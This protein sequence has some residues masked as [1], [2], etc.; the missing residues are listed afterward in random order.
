MQTQTKTTILSLPEEEFVHPGNRAC[1]GCSL[2]PSY[3]IVLKAPGA[4]SARGST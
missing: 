4:E 2:G 1:A 3:R